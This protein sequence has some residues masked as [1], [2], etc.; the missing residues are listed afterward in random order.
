M[1]EFEFKE[2]KRQYLKDLKVAYRRFMNEFID[3]NHNHSY[4]QKLNKMV[5][6]FINEDYKRMETLLYFPEFKLPE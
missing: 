4:D 6:E 2:Y 3:N 1:N 5:M